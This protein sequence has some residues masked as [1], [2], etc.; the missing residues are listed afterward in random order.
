MLN[1]IRNNI[2]TFRAYTR[3]TIKYYRLAGQ[4]PIAL[5]FLETLAPFLRRAV[6]LLVLFSAFRLY[7]ANIQTAKA[8][9]SFLHLAMPI[10]IGIA[11]Y[12]TLPPLT[13]A[14]I[15]FLR[16]RL[17]KRLRAAGL[18][19][20]AD[21][22]GIPPDH[23]TSFIYRHRRFSSYAIAAPFIYLTLY[24]CGEYVLLSFI[25]SE[26]L[27]WVGLSL[28]KVLPLHRS[29]S[30]RVLHIEG[31]FYL[32]FALYLLL[33]AIFL[34]FGPHEFSPE[35]LVIVIMLPR[36]QSRNMRGAARALMLR[37]LSV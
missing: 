13:G 37:R 36:V 6:T 33:L 35:L 29:L 16:R 2:R 19:K 30:H 9:D 5:L 8:S 15:F 32:S 7:V 28:V 4:I 12:L 27:F 24:L 22:F 1:S 23:F 34:Y 10:F 17:P 31:F 3:A 25:I 20:I 26:L 14:A 18:N 11:V 21:D